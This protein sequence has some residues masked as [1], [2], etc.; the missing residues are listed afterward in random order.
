VEEIFHSVLRLDPLN[1]NISFFQRN[2]AKWCIRNTCFVFGG[3]ERKK[4]KVSCYCHSG[5]K[6]ERR[7][8]GQCHAPAVFYPQEWTPGTHWRGGWVGLRAG[9]DTEARRKVLLLCWR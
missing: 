1:K 7:M 2:R 5:G 4:G 3:R 9:L 6:R 8:S